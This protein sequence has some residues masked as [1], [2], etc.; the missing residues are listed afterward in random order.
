[1]VSSYFT[2]PW[3]ALLSQVF[4]PLVSMVCYLGCGPLDDLF[5]L[6][7]QPLHYGF[8]GLWKF[9]QFGQSLTKMDKS[10]TSLEAKA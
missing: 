7:L 4:T 8:N 5:Q 9:L 6:R 3:L 1:M 2:V 10:N